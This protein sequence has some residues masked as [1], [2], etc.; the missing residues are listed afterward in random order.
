MEEKTRD[1]T[2]DLTWKGILVTVRLEEYCLWTPTVVEPLFTLH[3]DLS[4]ED[5]KKIREAVN[6][7][8]YDKER[9]K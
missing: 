2:L 4:L 8:I 6:T 1:I 9:A 3:D 7:A 5:L